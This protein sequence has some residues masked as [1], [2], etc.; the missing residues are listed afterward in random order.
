[1][2]PEFV[3]ESN[4]IFLEYWKRISRHN[5]AGSSWRFGTVSAVSTGTPNFNRVFVF[6][7]PDPENLSDGVSWMEEQNLQYRVSV[8]DS[9]L[10]G[11]AGVLT[12]LGFGQ[13]E[14]A[15]PAM[16]MTE[17]GELGR[18][19]RSLAIE[20]VRDDDGHEEYLSV[21]SEGFELSLDDTR[22][23]LPVSLLGDETIQL[24]VGRYDGEPVAAGSLFHPGEVAGVF[25]IAVSQEFRRRGLGEEITRAVLREGR[26][27]GAE[28][29]ALQATTPGYPLYQQ[30]GFDTSVWH[31]QFHPS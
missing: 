14:G 26:K 22:S 18:A 25:T 6:E 21:V 28:I 8:A 17:L 2:A 19:E 24:Y 1:M 16:V 30:M 23:W 11:T 15:V 12:E 31:Y 7:P 13:A 10:G 5:P 20:R 29:G 3:A 27:A 4:E 9:A